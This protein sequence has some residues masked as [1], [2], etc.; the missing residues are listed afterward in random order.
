MRLIGSLINLLL[1]LYSL[2]VVIYIFISLVKPAANRWTELLRGIVEPVLTPVR[3]L[4]QQHLPSQWQVVD[5]SPMVLLLLI[6]VAKNL[7]SA[8]F[9]F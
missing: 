2:A 4:L 6:W 3:R 9:S 7:F 1:S 5:W 8:I